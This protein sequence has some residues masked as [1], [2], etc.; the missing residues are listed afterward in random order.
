MEIET[1][2]WRDLAGNRLNRQV[3]PAMLSNEKYYKYVQ[4]RQVGNKERTLYNV[5]YDKDYALTWVRRKICRPLQILG[6][7]QVLKL[8]EKAWEL[9]LDE[10]KQESFCPKLVDRG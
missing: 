8:V 3:H 7:E 4:I 1:I 9:E 5:E 6:K 10:L 2:S